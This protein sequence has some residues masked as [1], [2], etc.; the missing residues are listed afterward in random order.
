MTNIYCLLLEKSSDKK[1]SLSVI[2]KNSIELLSNEKQV[3]QGN[4]GLFILSNY[5]QCSYCTYIQIH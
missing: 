2:L 1:D 5:M 4:Y 3:T